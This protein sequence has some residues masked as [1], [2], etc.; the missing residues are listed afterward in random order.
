[1]QVGGCCERDGC[2]KECEEDAHR[3]SR[4]QTLGDTQLRALVGT[5]LRW[6]QGP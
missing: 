4:R 3:V 2:E 1:M 5:C 6:R